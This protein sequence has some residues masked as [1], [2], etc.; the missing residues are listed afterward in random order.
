MSAQ[1]SWTRRDRDHWSSS[2]GDVKWVGGSWWGYPADKSSG[3]IELGP[4][5]RRDDAMA[6]VEIRI[7]DNVS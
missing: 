3:E 4:Y 1:Q 2:V 5:D 6:A 7:A